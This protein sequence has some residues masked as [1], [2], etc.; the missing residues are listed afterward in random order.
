MKTKFTSKTRSDCNWNKL[1]PRQRETVDG[2]L[3]QDVLSYEE[4]LGRVKNEFGV[5][6]SFASLSRYYQRRSHERQSTDL[7][8]VQAMAHTVTAPV[9]DVNAMRMATMKLIAKLALKTAFESPHRLRDLES[10][11]RLMLLG[12]DIE[13]RRSRVKLERE[14]F[15]Y[16]AAVAASQELPKLAG[17][18]LT[19]DQD[20]SLSSE[21]KLERIFNLLH[22]DKAR[23]GLHKFEELKAEED[24]PEEEEEEDLPE[25]EIEEEEPPAEDPDQ[26]GPSSAPAPPDSAA[27]TPPAAVSAEKPLPE[28]T[29]DE[30][31][32]QRLTRLAELGDATSAH[33]LGVYYRDGFRVPKDLIKARDWL[34][35]AGDRGCGAA[36]IALMG[37]LS[38]HPEL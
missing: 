29:A 35:K 16:K 19:I 15:L 22:P 2:W 12:E 33:A 30:K 10:L 26:S 20:E 34:S 1:T 14:Q 17:L 28:P 18:I 21:E 38:R 9:A 24:E 36:K 32:L 7:V 13:I 27:A 5:K 11:T 23:M 4:I 3:F 6:S 37:L 25:E 8:S 31:E